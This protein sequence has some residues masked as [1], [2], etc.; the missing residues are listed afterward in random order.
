MSMA[1]IG[2]GGGS[3]GGSHGEEDALLDSMLNLPARDEKEGSSAKRA[4]VEVAGN[5]EGVI[6][7]I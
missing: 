6:Y 3:G 5:G 4:R 7:S 2:S 1:M